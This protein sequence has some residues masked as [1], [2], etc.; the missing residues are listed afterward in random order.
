MNITNEIIKNIK[1]EKQKF[2]FP[3]ID[4]RK[5]ADLN[6]MMASGSELSRKIKVKVGARKGS[7]RKASVENMKVTSISPDSSQLSNI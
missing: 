4:V 1:I 7:G 6:E 2:G 3:Q 5:K